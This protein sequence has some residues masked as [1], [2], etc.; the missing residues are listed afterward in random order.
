MTLIDEKT[1]GVKIVKEARY[2]LYIKY[3]NT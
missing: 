3:V 1:T 2:L